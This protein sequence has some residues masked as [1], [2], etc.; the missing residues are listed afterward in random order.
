MSITILKDDPI[1]LSVP[2]NASDD[3]AAAIDKLNTWLNSGNQQEMTLGGLAGTGKT[4]LLKSVV[5]SLHAQGLTVAVA[6]LAGKAVAVL[7]SKGLAHAQTLHSLLYEPE[8]PP[9]EWSMAKEVWRLAKKNST[10]FRTRNEMEMA[11]QHGD[12]AKFSQADIAAWKEWQRVQRVYGPHVSEEPEWVEVEEIPA[13]IV[14]VD[15]ASMVPYDVLHSLRKHQVPV[16]FVG[17]H[18]QLEPVGENP[19]LMVNPEIRLETIHRQAADSEILQFAHYVRQ[20]GEPR[21]W[22][23]PGRDVILN[24]SHIRYADFDAVLCGYNKFRVHLNKVIRHERGIPDE[25]PVDGDTLICLQNKRDV[26]LYNGHITTAAQVSHYRHEPNIVHLTVPNAGGKLVSVK[27]WL[28]QFGEPRQA[29]YI[30]RD[31]SMFDWGYALTTH[32]CVGGETLV[33]VN[34]KWSRIDALGENT[35]T[36]ATAEGERK[37]FRF[38]TRRTASLITLECEQ[39][40]RITVTPDHKM[41]VF[42]DGEWVWRRADRLTENEFLRVKLG[43]VST[44]PGEA[45][46]LPKLPVGDP[47][48]YRFRVPALTEELAEFLGLMVADGTRYRTGVRLAKRHEDVVRRFAE[49][50]LRL[51]GLTPTFGLIGST[52]KA[53]FHS[54]LLSEWLRRVG[55]M[56]PHEKHIPPSILASPPHIRGAFLRGLFEDGTV[57]LK[58]SLIDHIEWANCSSELTAVVQTLLLEFGIISSVAHRENGSC[59]YIYSD[60]IPVFADNIGFIAEFKNRRLRDG[61]L[62]RNTKMRVPIR[63]ECFDCSTSTGKNARQRGYISRATAADIGMTSELEYHYVRVKKFVH[64]RGPSYCLEVPACGSFL[65]NR[66]DGS[67]SQGSEW[68][69]V[70]VVEQIWRE[71]WS[72]ER[73]RYTAATRAAKRLIYLA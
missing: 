29:P 21:K 73:W 35:G 38:I 11:A 28:P 19:G 55:G 30:R 67:N 12:F 7:K 72:P 47:R 1:P 43:R 34:G 51:F 4:T 27:A 60:S 52:L 9:E 16:L 14:I 61:N 63:R 66:F 36:V 69:L 68:D 58:G 45:A 3:Q 40:Y 13:D 39:G 5:E 62:S 33:E 41:R 50:G 37:F 70:A 31:I 44:H 71:K 46:Q 54:V 59:L 49:L 10:A 64:H 17:D 18:G 42:H 20:G 23:G 32:K 24:P 57:N 53:E 25:L 15:E 48:A 65:Q 8:G 56:D 22:N 2:A 26:G 6:A